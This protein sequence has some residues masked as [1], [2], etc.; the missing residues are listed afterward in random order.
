MT[1]LHLCGAGNSEGVRL[2]QAVNRQLGLWDRIV[3]LDDDPAKRG[4]ALLGVEIVGG[5]DALASAA[6]PARAANLVARTT[7]KRRAARLRMEAHGVRFAPLIYPDVDCDGVEFDDDAIVYQ[8]ATLGPEA[9]LGAGT[10]VFMGAVVGHECRVGRC[11]VIAANAVLNARVKL[12]DGA[13][14]GTNA[15]VLPEIEIGQGATVGAGSVVVQGVPAG[16]TVMGV[17]AEVLMFARE[18]WANETANVAPH[19]IADVAAH[20]SRE[21]PFE[22]ALAL[23][24][25]ETLNVAGVGCQDNFFDL[26]GDSLTA[27]RIRDRIRSELK[28]ELCLADLFRYPTVCSLANHLNGGSK[29]AADVGAARGLERARRIGLSS[30]RRRRAAP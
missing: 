30:A 16:A 3:L 2:A 28:E 4:R 12:G 17:P 8:H 6:S 25:R 26:G 10:V 29:A 23:I 7:A 15:T 20:G 11:C 5:F 24:W 1:T 9:T 14:V 27:L 13:Y 21:S 19:V 22:S 18:E